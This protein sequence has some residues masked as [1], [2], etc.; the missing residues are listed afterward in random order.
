MI[1]S[2]RGLVEN[3]GND[4]LILEVGNFGFK[5]FASKRTLFKTSML[6]RQEISIFCFLRVR[7][8][9][10]DLFGFLSEPELKFFEMLNGVS[11]VGPKLALAIMDV[12]ELAELVSAIKEGR[13]DLLTKTSGVGEKTAQRIVLELRNKVQV[14]GSSQTVKKMEDDRDIVETLVSLGYRKEEARLALDKV[15]DK[16]LSMEERLKRVLKVLSKK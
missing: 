11:G 1:H 3:T 8:D 10:I 15:E 4:H 14:T 9:G 13:A 16:T 2:L 6:N 5:V 12:A 7:E